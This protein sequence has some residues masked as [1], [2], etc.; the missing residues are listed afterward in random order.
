MKNRNTRRGFTQSC[1]PKGFTLIELL[2]VVLIIGILAAV[3]VPQY[4]KAVYKA[5]IAEYQ[6]NLQSIG[7]AAM[8]CKLQKGESCALEE[9]DIDA[10]KCKVFPQIA[11]LSRYG[12]GNGNECIYDIDDTSVSVRMSGATFPLF[13]YYY[14]PTQVLGSTPSGGQVEVS[15]FYCVLDSGNSSCSACRKLGFSSM[16]SFYNLCGK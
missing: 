15:G 5:Q 14:E 8:A 4:Q 7:H 10:P 2:V 6:T 12:K 1:F 13:S 16:V 9:L 11:N 3:A